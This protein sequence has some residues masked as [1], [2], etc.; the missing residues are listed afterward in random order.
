MLRDLIIARLKAQVSGLRKVG[1]AA[2]LAGAQADTQNQFPCAFV[3][4]LA[5]QGGA[6]RYMSGLTAQKRTP[7]IAVVLAVKNVRDMIGNASGGDMELLRQQTDAALF[8]WM[9]DG[10]HA[11]LIFASGKLMGLLGGELWWQDEY[12]TEFDRR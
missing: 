2:D 4:V 5:E 6:P 7:R 12:T 3:L 10:D 1:T 11:P 9:P 8:G